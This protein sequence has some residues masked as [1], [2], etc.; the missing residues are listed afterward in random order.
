MVGVSPNPSLL[1]R[2]ERVVFYGLEHLFVAVSNDA[3]ELSQM[4]ATAEHPPVPA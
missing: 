4:Q 2:D 3:P 1:F